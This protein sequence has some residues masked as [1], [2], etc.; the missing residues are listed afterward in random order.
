MFF[1][2]DQPLLFYELCTP[3]LLVLD[4][5]DWA[6]SEFSL[7]FP[8]TSV[9][10]S[11]FSL[12]TQPQEP[13]DIC[14]WIPSSIHISPPASLFFFPF[15]FLPIFHVP[16]YFT[17]R[18]CT[19]CRGAAFSPACTFI[20]EGTRKKCHLEILVSSRETSGETY[21]GSAVYWKGRNSWGAECVIRPGKKGFL[22]SKVVPVVLGC[23][24][25]NQE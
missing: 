7:L 6:C 20:G 15:P 17:P 18:P 11:L 4:N 25:S 14:I 13:L 9:C 2:W 19:L 12:H 5:K 16:L 3:S 23:G 10:L 21:N 22:N 1:L 24:C 8:L